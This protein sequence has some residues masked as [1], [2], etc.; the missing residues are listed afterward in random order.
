MIQIS[1]KEM[2]FVHVHISATQYSIG[3]EIEFYYQRY[4][5]ATKLGSN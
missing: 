1:F 5:G 3:M 2:S 4:I